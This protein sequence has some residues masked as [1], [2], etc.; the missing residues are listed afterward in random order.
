LTHYEFTSCLFHSCKP[1]WDWRVDD[2]HG[3]GERSRLYC[4]AY[5]AKAA[6]EYAAEEY[7][8][9]EGYILRTGDTIKIHVR[10]GNTGD[11]SAWDVYG[12]MVPQ[13]YARESEDVSCPDCRGMRVVCAIPTF[14]G[15]EQDMTPCPTCNGTGTRPLV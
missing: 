14:M 3:E 11:V 4:R 9:A 13:Y 15:Q 7:D 5:D 2:Y 8:E 10:S 12:E 6:A 1:S